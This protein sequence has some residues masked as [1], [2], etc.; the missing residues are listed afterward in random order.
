MTE[1]GMR[2]QNRF[3]WLLLGASTVAALLIA[4]PFFRPLGF[5]I[6]IA[7][8]F[9][10]IH[11][12]MRRKVKQPTLAAL[13]STLV[14]ALVVAIPVALIATLGGQQLVHAAHYLSN[15]SS[16][17]GGIAAWAAEL[18]D[19]PLSWV[20]QHVGVEREDIRSH[21]GSLSARISQFLLS[22]GTS[23]LGSFAAL[24][25]DL[26]LTF[27]ILFFLFRDGPRFMDEV[28][29][30][31]P[32]R[33]ERADK[34]LHGIHA[35]VIGNLYGILSVGAAQGVLTGIAMLITGIPSAFL[36]GVAAGLAS[37]IPVIG[38]AL[39][40]APA[41]IYLLLTHHIWQG[42]FM[43]AWGGAVISTV[44]NILRP[45]V[46]AGK[47]PLHPLV[48]LIALIGGVAQFGFLGLFIGPVVV[49]VIVTVLDILREEGYLKESV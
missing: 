48:L 47:V 6:V 18:L 38:S 28:I 19:R 44:D 3:L 20:N 13:A 49:S 40:W 33:K 34:L 35:S 12:R 31:L 42:V 29:G 14:V 2:I 15:R 32:L 17:E 25:G 39:V 8:G 37:I 7:L 26:L 24:A 45:L 46:I 5:A 16:A 41:A 36:L 1:T 23:F 22:M 21:I 10:S 11:Q 27:F 30:A 4:R 43:L 9:D